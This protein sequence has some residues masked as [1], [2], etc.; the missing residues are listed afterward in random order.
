VTEAIWKAP[1]VNPDF[2]CICR[3]YGGH[4]WRQP[5]DRRCQVRRQVWYLT[6]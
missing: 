4:S 1:P 2:A 3:T 5:R 6:K